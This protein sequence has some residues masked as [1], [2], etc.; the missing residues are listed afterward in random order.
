MLESHNYKHSLKFRNTEISVH[1]EK[2]YPK[3]T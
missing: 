1:N 3:E 2:W